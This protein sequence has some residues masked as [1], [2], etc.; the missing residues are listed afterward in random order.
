MSCSRTTT[1]WRRWGSKLLP[2]GL[3]SSTL[4]LSHCAPSL[5]LTL[6]IL[7]IPWNTLS[8]C[9]NILST[10]EFTLLSR[11]DLIANASVLLNSFV[12]FRDPSGRM[13]SMPN[14]KSAFLPSNG[15]ELIL[16][17]T[18]IK[19]VSAPLVW[20]RAVAVN[21]PVTWSSF[22]R[23]LNFVW[24]GLKAPAE[25]SCRVPTYIV[26]FFKFILFINIFYFKSSHRLKWISGTIIIIVN[27]NN[28]DFIARRGPESHSRVN[29]DFSWF[30]MEIWE[31]YKRAWQLFWK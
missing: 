10:S 9:F 22:W 2:F 19:V 24:S 7:P 8:C 21:S 12:S 28:F 5:F 4:P 29:Q 27:Y 6:N 26:Y 15:G 16:P 18:T 31:V 14:S 25:P 13:S 1:Q 3:E 23:V 20:L 30:L 17:L 11:T